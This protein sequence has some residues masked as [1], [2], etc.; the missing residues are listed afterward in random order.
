MELHFIVGRRKAFGHPNAGS[1]G[2]AP[3]GSGKFQMIEI[4]YPTFFLPSIGAPSG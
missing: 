1:G 4:R 2:S 3:R